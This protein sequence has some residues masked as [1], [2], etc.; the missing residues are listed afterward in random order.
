M[1]LVAGRRVAHHSQNTELVLKDTL[2]WTRL[3]VQDLL[4]DVT[5]IL[6]VGHERAGP[7]REKSP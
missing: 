1:R 4:G 6:A 5:L 3:I 2:R 7:G